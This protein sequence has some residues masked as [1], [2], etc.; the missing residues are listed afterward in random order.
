MRQIY[1]ITFMRRTYGGDSKFKP[2]FRQKSNL[3]EAR[4]G[5]IGAGWIFHEVRAQINCFPG[6]TSLIVN[7]K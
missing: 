2:E 7:M 1:D 3:R 5:I 4:C 6:C